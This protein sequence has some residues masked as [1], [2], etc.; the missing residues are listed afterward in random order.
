MSTEK[1][2]QG[3]VPALYAAN[4]WGEQEFLSEAQQQIE[5]A[6]LA[7]RVSANSFPDFSFDPPEENLAVLSAA[8]AVYGV[9]KERSLVYYSAHVFGNFEEQQLEALKMA[10]DSLSYAILNRRMQVAEWERLIPEIQG[11]SDLSGN[12]IRPLFR[13]F[14]RVPSTAKMKDG[15]PERMPNEELS[16]VMRADWKRFIRTL[17]FMNSLQLLTPEEYSAFQDFQ[18]SKLQETPVRSWVDSYYYLLSQELALP[19]NPPVLLGKDGEPAKSTKDSPLQELVKQHEDAGEKEQAKEIA[20]A[21]I[22]IISVAR[23]LQQGGIAL[24]QER[25]RVRGILAEGAAKVFEAGGIQ[26]RFALA[27]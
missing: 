25:E 26:P 5:Q 23:N 13:C 15:P 21:L 16:L 14:R 8:G 11:K 12:S 27:K 3:I 17:P 22:N 6:G 24:S 10:S 20:G 7:A 19:E 9:E 1:G 4:V 18:G 2:L